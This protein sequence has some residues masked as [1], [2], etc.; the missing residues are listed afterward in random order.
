[1]RVLLAV[2]LFLISTL[3]IA[4][5]QQSNKHQ[6]LLKRA[7]VREAQRRLSQ[8]GYWT[9]AVNGRFDPATQSALIAFQKWEGRP[10]TGELTLGE[11]H[12][13]RS[14][15]PPKA[16]ETGYAHVEVDIDRQ[17]LLIIGESGEV[18]VLPVST[19][20][21][22]EFIEEGQTSI[23]YTPRGRFMVYDKIS[24]WDGPPGGMY[25]SN[26]ISGGVAI[27]GYPSVPK[28]PASHGCIRIPIFAAREVSRLLT[29]GTIV[30]VYDKV[31]FVSAKEWAANPKLKQ[32][33]LLSEAFTDQDEFSIPRPRQH[34]GD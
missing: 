11:L 3:S 10:I 20:S 19:G 18:R 15:A 30:L 16:R 4:G 26:Y 25:Y 23:A 5:A 6:T 34:R 24:D 31:S 29:V 22:R 1:M 12:A 17:V 32:A 13:I 9:V 7:E 27:H 28:E 8:L 33:A 21:G 14:S 2:S